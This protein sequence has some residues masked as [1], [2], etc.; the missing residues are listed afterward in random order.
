[1]RNRF[2]TNFSKQ[3]SSTYFFMLF[4]RYGM[5]R[6]TLFTEFLPRHFEEFKS[7]KESQDMLIGNGRKFQEEKR[8]TNKRDQFRKLRNRSDWDERRYSQAKEDYEALDC[9]YPQL[10]QIELYRVFSYPWV[11]S[12]C[13]PGISFRKSE[14]EHIPYGA[15]AQQC[16]RICFIRARCV[17]Q[18][19][20]TTAVFNIVV[21]QKQ[22]TQST[23]SV[24]FDDNSA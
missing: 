23:L 10:T 8:V 16:F 21:L 18:Q 2:S 7:S 4:V 11:D 14:I 24:V 12:Q 6:R 9:S 20:A 17:L 22:Q 19:C 5:A 3:W 1:M 15:H 13:P